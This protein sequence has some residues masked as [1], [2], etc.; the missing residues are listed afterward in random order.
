[1]LGYGVRPGLIDGQWAKPA[2]GVTGQRVCL[3]CHGHELLHASW[4]S[5]GFG[6]AMS[7]RVSGAGQRHLV[8]SF[9]RGV[10]GRQRALQGG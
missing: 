10:E 6:Q 3:R 1:M 4:R 9:V 5:R 7:V 8:Y 2:L